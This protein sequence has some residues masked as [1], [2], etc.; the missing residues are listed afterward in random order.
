MIRKSARIRWFVS[1]DGA[2]VRTGT[3]KAVLYSLV[4][5]LT[6]KTIYIKVV[7][8]KIGKQEIYNDGDYTDHN[9]AEFALMAWTDSNEMEGIRKDWGLT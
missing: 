7:Y 5:T 1:V 8:G 6:W 4:R 9:R 3:K 2:K